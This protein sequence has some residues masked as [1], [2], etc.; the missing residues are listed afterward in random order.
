MICVWA[1]VV[2]TLDGS[3]I[4]AARPWGSELQRARLA[5]THLLRLTRRRKEHY[6]KAL[7]NVN[8]QRNALHGMREDP[9][10][11]TREQV[12]RVLLQRPLQAES[13]A[14]VVDSAAAAR[15]GNVGTPEHSLR[16]HLNRITVRR[17]EAEVM[18]TRCARQKNQSVAFGHGVAVPGW[19][20]RCRVATDA[21]L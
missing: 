17:G 19:T 8:R 1:V 18:G 4:P 14:V 10:W 11:H 16:G 13:Q 9:P 7:A 21:D 20:R 2:S 3:R 5:S 15:R 6:V 12:R